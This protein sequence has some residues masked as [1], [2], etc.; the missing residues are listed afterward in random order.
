MIS[1][2]NLEQIFYYVRLRTK[3][4]EG[5][6]GA[7]KQKPSEEGFHS[8]LWLSFHPAIAISKKTNYLVSAGAASVGAGVAAASAGAASVAG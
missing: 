8:K 6:S 5:S 3:S 2:R 1:F 7:Q 4:E